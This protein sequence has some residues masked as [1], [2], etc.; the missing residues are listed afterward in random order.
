MRII[1]VL[2]LAVFATV[3]ASLPAI[4]HDKEQKLAPWI[5]VWQ[6]VSGERSGVKM[7][8][9]STGGFF[10]ITKD[11]IT[12]MNA[13]GEVLS[14]L[15]YKLDGEQTPVP[16]TLTTEKPVPGETREAIIGVKDGKLFM[17]YNLDK[18]ARP[19]DF[20]TAKDGNND[21]L[22]V[23]VPS[24]DPREVTKEVKALS[25]KKWLAFQEEDAAFFNGQLTSPRMMFIGRDG[26]SQDRYNLWLDLSFENG[27]GEPPPTGWVAKKKDPKNKIDSVKISEQ[28]LKAFGDTV[29][30]T[31][32]SVA[33]RKDQKEPVWDVR[34]T[35]VWVRKNKEWQLVSEQHTTAR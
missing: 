28:T 2:L 1:F 10:A 29:I 27:R 14:L 13:E 24:Y 11:T 25:E 12:G 15:S 26:F 23:F 4:G 16:I 5:G 22:M 35:S 21:R 9:T 20:T 17:V 3:I 30:E 6:L 34:Y 32:R 7:A 18:K 8:D 31:G 33:N 19:K